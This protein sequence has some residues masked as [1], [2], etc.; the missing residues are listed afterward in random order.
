MSK[1][2]IN[3]RKTYEK[4]YS[5]EFRN[6]LNRVEKQA[7]D[8]NM[9]EITPDYVILCALDDKDSMLYKC[10]G[11]VKNIKFKSIYDELYEKIMMP[12]KQKTSLNKSILPSFS[13]DTTFLL[14]KCEEERKKKKNKFITS[15]HFL[16]AYLI[17]FTNGEAFSILE[18]NGITYDS[19]NIAINVLHG[20]TDMLGI[21][22][23]TSIKEDDN[24][25]I[26]ITMDPSMTTDSTS[27]IGMIRDMTGGFGGPKYATSSNPNDVE[28][29]TNLN[30]LAKDKK[31]DR[32]IGREREI[33]EII[34]ILNRKNNNNALIVG[35][36]GVG[37]TCL[38]EGIA[39]KIVDNEIPSI[40]ADKVIWRLSYSSLVAGTTL[41]GMVE[42]RVKNMLAKL[43]KLKNAILF[44]DDL[45]NASANSKDGNEDGPISLFSEFLSDSAIQIIVCTNYSGYR[46]I[47][48]SSSNFSNKFQ[49]ILLDKPSYE[50]CK[51][52]INKS[53][54]L[55]EKFHSVKYDETIS[56]MCITLADRYITDMTLPSSAIGLIDE[57]GSYKHLRLDSYDRLN[58]NREK[59]NELLDKKSN[60]IKEDKIDEANKI[61]DEIKILDKE[62]A[63]II[64][65]GLNKNPIHVTIEDVYKVLSEK[66]GIPLKKLSVSDK[67]NLKNIESTLKKDVVGQDEAINIIGRAIKRSKVGLSSPN[68]PILTCMCIGKSGCGKTLLAKK[69][70]E[71]VFGDEKYLVRFDMSEYSDKTSIN[72]LIGSS[73]GYV[74]Y[75]D[76]GLLTEAVKK[77][78]YAVLL[79]DEIEKANEEVFNLFLQ[80]LD[81][82]I[83]TDGT[84][85]KAD[86]K[87]TIIILTSN[88]GTKQASNDHGFG[89]SNDKDDSYKQV[90]EKELKK[91]FPPEFINRLDEIVYFNTLTDENLKQ[92]IKLEIAKLNK[93]LSNNHLSLTYSDE[94]IDY[95]LN[96]VSKDKDYG[97][98]PII[99]AI[100][101]EIENKIIDLLLDN[102]VE[103]ENFNFEIKNN[104]VIVE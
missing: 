14:K 98:R 89:F 30:K 25:E 3:N 81:E 78:K 38:V 7:Y 21:I 101:N 97:A 91:K 61:D 15:D 84:G 54:P 52:I 33:A 18:K 27:I 55:Y 86:F 37:K 47:F 42:E 6:F 69:I 32:V 64:D 11:E 74:G 24:N 40:M 76:G 28:Y 57:I 79:I 63:D 68:K 58:A 82:G 62:T 72:R 99:R 41:R 23:D 39:K 53:I 103:N 92:I 59:K 65:E 100:Q 67:S 34:R 95:I 96:I 1:Q 104:E 12:T 45:E 70:A 8:D 2:P 29:C 50:E 35:D 102:E 4:N 85:N 87:N 31:I 90:I 5:K 13:S 22:D 56:E 73:A 77:R 36:S 93:R 43:R 19:I 94:V 20:I 16:S 10:I 71:N 75:K 80:V 48:E 49:K 17:N 60:L 26:I 51:E 88:V 46:T 9:F 83:L 66:T 44:I